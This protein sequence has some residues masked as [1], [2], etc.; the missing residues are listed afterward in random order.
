MKTLI[1]GAGAIGT[2]L[3][4]YMTR[5]GAGVTM[6]DLPETATRLN[7]EP[8]EI[9]TNSGVSFKIRLKAVDDSRLLKEID[10]V[11]VCVKTF[12]TDEAVSSIA[13]L[14]DRIQAIVSIQNGVDKEGILE[15]YFGRDKVIGGCCLEAAT[16]EDEMI[17]RHTMSVIT[18]LGELDGSITPRVR[19]A[20]KMM[21]D[22]G[23]KAEASTKVVSADWCKWINFAGG[24]AI[25]GLTGLPYYKALLNPHS[26]DLI[27]QLYCEYAELATASGVEVD[28]YPGFEVKTISRASREEA[29]RLLQRRGEDLKAKGATKVMASL[30]RDLISG[31]PTERES[32]FGFALREAQVKNVSMPL[33]RHVYALISAMEQSREY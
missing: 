17:I 11:I 2:L 28:D 22:G 20:V 15:R 12:H 14:R 10:F 3:G 24:S 27:A 26:A 4:A 19:A 13:H 21:N 7:K 23:L 8:V 1:L 31:R 9:I 6:L 18:Y 32:I 30:A 25:C 29:V 5:G 33:T 16:R